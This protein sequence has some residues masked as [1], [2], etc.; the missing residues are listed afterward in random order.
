MSVRAIRGAT[1]LQ[2]DDAAEMMDAVTE[3]LAQMQQRNELAETQF[4][5]ILFT[6]TPDLRAAFPAEAARRIGFTDVALMCAQEMD[7]AGAMPRVVRVL[8][9]VDVDRPRDQIKHVFLRGAQ[10]L[11]RDLADG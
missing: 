4:L 5:S 1:C 6:A 10:A 3:L 8:A 11:R 2:A 7:V 9:Y